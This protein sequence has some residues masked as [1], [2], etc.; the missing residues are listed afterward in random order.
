MLIFYEHSS[1]KTQLRKFGFACF[2][3]AK[4]FFIAFLK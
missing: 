3:E 1:I 2:F 4:Q